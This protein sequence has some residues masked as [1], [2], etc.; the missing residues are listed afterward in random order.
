MTEVGLERRDEPLVGPRRN[1][2]GSGA[3]MCPH[4]AAAHAAERQ[5]RERAVRGEALVRNVAGTGL[6]LHVHDHGGLPVIRHFGVKSDRRL[7]PAAAVG[8]HHEAAAGQAAHAR[9]FQRDRHTVFVLR[10]ACRRRWRKH[11]YAAQPLVQ[12]LAEHTVG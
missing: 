11:F 12:H 9:L 8:Q 4:D 10:E 5:H 6:D 2:G 3:F 7:Q 1:R